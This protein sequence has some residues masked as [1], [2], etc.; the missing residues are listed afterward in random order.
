MLD[1]VLVSSD[2]AFRH[3]SL[4]VVR[5]PAVQARIALDLQVSVDGLT[6]E[7]IGKILEVSPRV[8][9]LDLG[10]NP[11]GLKGISALTQAAPEVLLIV[12]GPAL[13]ADGLLSVMRAGATEYLPRPLSQDE[14]QDAFNRVRR[15]LKSEVTASPREM[16]RVS[17]VFSAKGGT[18]VTTIATNLAIALRVQTER[19][20]LLLDLEPALG[21]ASVAMG[22]QPR[23]T[24]LDVVRNFHRIDEELFRSYLEDHESGVQVLA[25]PLSILET[26]PPS[27]ED[28]LGLISF[29]K[30]Y[31]DFVVIDGGSTVSSH[32]LLTLQESEEKVLV[33]TP[34]LPSLRNQKQALSILARV[35]GAAPPRVVLN[36][37]KDGIGLSLGDIEDGLGQRIS[38]ILDKDDSRV[39]ESINLGRPEVLVGK[40]RFAKGLLG[41]GGELAGE[42]KL[43]VQKA[44]FITRVF[45]SSKGGKKKGKEVSK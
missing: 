11:S 37:Y 7:S 39:L 4:G 42:D 24:Y 41:L 12:A 34:D 6:M 10:Q 28:L 2:E 5:Q 9:F 20:V 36:Q 19:D 1:C 40:S 35:N 45:G 17:T 29:C 8:V 38:V 30:Q 32:L 44:G 22:V 16:G 18:G 27:A 3:A 13:S 21:T 43:D 26:E 31:F 14:T 23:Y 15:R 25:S 33:V